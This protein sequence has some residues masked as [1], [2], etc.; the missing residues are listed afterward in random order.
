MNKSKSILAQYFQSFSS[1]EKISKQK[2][3]LQTL[4]DVNTD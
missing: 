2:A 4:V 1:L 3:K